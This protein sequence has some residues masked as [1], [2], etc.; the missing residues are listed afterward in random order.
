MKNFKLK[1]L[2]DR[3]KSNDQKVT[4][5]GLGR[6]L[7]PNAKNPYRTAN[8][9]VVGNTTRL[10]PDQVTALCKYLDCKPNELYGFEI[11]KN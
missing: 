4:W 5:I 1:Q 8:N 2:F 9:L 3:A 10:S 6:V 7:D 11:I